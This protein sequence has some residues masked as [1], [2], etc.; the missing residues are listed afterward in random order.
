MSAILVAIILGLGLGALIAS[1]ALS[2][3]LNYRGAGAINLGFGAVATLAAFLFYSLHVEGDFLFRGLSVGGR[4]ATVP[5]LGITL[6]ACALAGAAWD[7]GVLRALRSASALAKM[8]VSLGLLLV[9][10]SSMVLEF[11]NS[12]Q[13]APS[14]LPNVGSL[15]IGGQSVPFNRLVVAGIVLLIAV[16]LAASYRWSRF[17][18]STRAAAGNEVAAMLN[19]LSPNRLSLANTTLSFVCAGALGVLVA[20]M[21]SLDPVTITVAIIPALAAALLARFTSFSVAALAGLAL[22]CVQSLLTYLETKS[23]FPTSGGLALPGTSDLLNFLIIA[24][25][26]YFRGNSLPVR[27]A[28]IEARLPSAPAARRIGLPLAVLLVAGA[29][30]V[31]F[32]PYDFRQALITS[33]IGA[34]VCLSLVVTTGFVGQTSLAQIALAGVSAFVI[35]HLAISSGIGFPIAPLIAALAATVFGV[36]IGLPA[37]RVRGVNLAILSMAAAVAIENFGFNNATWGASI[38]GSTVPSPTLLGINLGPSAAFGLGPGSLPSPMFGL[39]CLVVLALAS[40]SVAGVRRSTLGHRMLAVRS[41]ERAAAATGIPVA[42]VKLGAVALSSFIAGLAG[43]LYAYDLGSVSAATFDI[44]V[45]FA[46]VAF[47]YVGGI[48]TVTGA[49]IGGF[50]ASDG[51]GITLIRHATGLPATW[52]ILFAGAA[53]IV[54]VIAN[55]A[56]VAGGLREQLGP[57]VAR[58]FRLAATGGPPQAA[59]GRGAQ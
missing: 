52:A 48:T 1:L 17:G 38:Y 16:A 18:L 54:T 43:A 53:L 11:G 8:V 36:A 32:L 21:V 28:L 14:V 25:V 34:L 10:Q 2:V 3:V 56:G 59:G 9:V 57:L 13:V 49:L 26:L 4:V 55:P 35:A 46:F 6:L 40:V 50:M 44:L 41:N 31:I 42:S 58:A 15:S 29:A 12:G 45:S 33:L 19:G 22:G 47:A 30:A 51:L 23:W 24:A 5:A 39:V 27:G 7:I 20:P 37:L